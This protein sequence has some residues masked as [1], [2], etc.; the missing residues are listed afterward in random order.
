[1]IRH[2]SLKHGWFYHYRVHQAKVEDLCNPKFQMLKQYLDRIFSGCPD[3]YFEDGPR[4]SGL[5][6]KFPLKVK[7]ITGHEVSTLAREGLRLG[8]YKTGHSKVE[9]FMLERDDSTVAVEVPIWIHANEIPLYNEMFN[10]DKPLTGHIDILRVEGDK[11]W[12]WDYKPNAHKE[13]FADTQTYFYAMMLSKRTGI[14]I[15]NFRCGYFDENTAYAF[16]PE[17][18][19]VN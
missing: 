18:E 3:E 6:F 15:S 1:M 11:I 17:E 13:K 19:L 5:K 10:S 16:K 12:V 9:C 4:S 14:D 8:A 2:L 7:R